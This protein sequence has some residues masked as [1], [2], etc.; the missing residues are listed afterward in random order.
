MSEESSTLKNKDQLKA[1]HTVEF[2]PN[3]KVIMGVIYTVGKEG[4]S[5]DQILSLENAKLL[6]DQKLMEKV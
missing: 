2:S 5:K 3:E 1:L 6:F 4:H